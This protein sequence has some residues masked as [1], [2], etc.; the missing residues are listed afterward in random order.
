MNVRVNAFF[1]GAAGRPLLQVGGYWKDAYTYSS[2]HRGYAV[3]RFPA[4]IN[5]DC[6]A[7]TGCQTNVT[8]DG[9]GSSPRERRRLRSRHGDPEPADLQLGLRYDRNTIRRSPRTRRRISRSR[10]AAGRRL[11]RCRS[12]RRLQQRVAAARPHL[13]HSR[14]RQDVARANYASYWGTGWNG[15]HRQPAQSHFARRRPLSVD[16]RQRRQVCQANE[17]LASNRPLA[18]T[19]NWD[20]TIRRRPRPRTASSIAND[21]TGE[22]IVGVDHGSP[23]ASASASTTSGAATPASIGRTSTADQRRYSPSASRRPHRLVR[24]RRRVVRPSR[25]TSRIFSCD[26]DDADQCRRVQS[27]VQR[28]EV[29]GRRRLSTTG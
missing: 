20:R 29:T 28:C 2:T 18:V 6:A 22:F 17:I 4:S 11:P 10:V 25:S 8:R 15:R 9:I 19:G 5:D 16:R 24:R 14:Q 12:W 3:A 21:R 7:S 26:R 13:R 23:P 1:R 27:G